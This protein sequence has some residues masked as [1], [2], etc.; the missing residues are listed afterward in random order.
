ME[1]F[2][3]LVLFLTGIPKHGCFVGGARSC[4]TTVCTSLPPGRLAV[5]QSLC[6]D[7]PRPEAMGESAF[8]SPTSASR[9]VTARLGAFTVALGQ[10]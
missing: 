1:S 9:A 7:T 5:A 2:L 6:C 8:S 3:G 4:K 10:D